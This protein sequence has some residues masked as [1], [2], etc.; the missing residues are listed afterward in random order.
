[1]DDEEQ[2]RRE[3][4]LKK[5]AHREAKQALAHLSSEH[6]T[7]VLADTDADEAARREAKREKK[8]R[9]REAALAAAGQQDRADEGVA[10]AAVDEENV[11]TT[12]H[13]QGH[14][15]TVQGAPTALAAVGDKQAAAVG[16]AI[17]K[18]F[19]TECAGLAA[20][21]QAVRSL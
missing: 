12:F 5:K 10:P 13:Q 19:Y 14:V 15:G 17:K 16:R 8:R 4:K 6:D 3:R 18:S 21:S 9:R 2:A 20:L 7:P 11:R 1:M